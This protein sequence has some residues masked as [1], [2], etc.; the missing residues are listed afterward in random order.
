MNAFGTETID[1]LIADVDAAIS[2]PHDRNIFLACRS[3]GTDYISIAFLHCEV[4]RQI[5]GKVIAC[6]LRAKETIPDSA[7]TTND[8]AEIQRLV[9]IVE[10]LPDTVVE[11]RAKEE[12]EV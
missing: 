9:Q 4:Q 10:C 6:L 3:L 8:R 11:Q 7:I 1:D 2:Q 5:Q 12:Y